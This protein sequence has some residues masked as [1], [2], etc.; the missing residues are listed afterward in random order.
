MLRRPTRSI[1]RASRKHCEASNFTF[2][3]LTRARTTG[4]TLSLVAPKPRRILPIQLQFGDRFTDEEG[5]WEVTG[6][7]FT[8]REEKVVHTTSRSQVRPRALRRRPEGPMSD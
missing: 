2:L 5:A 7:P 8:T 3:L 4:A 1:V 6:H